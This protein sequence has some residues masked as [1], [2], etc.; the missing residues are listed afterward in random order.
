MTREEQGAGGLEISP[1]TQ[2]QFRISIADAVIF[3]CDDDADD[4][5]VFV[6]RITNQLKE[7]NIDATIFLYD[8]L[9]QQD[10]VLQAVDKQCKLSVQHWF[11]ITDSFCKDKTMMLHKDEQIVKSLM[12][13]NSFIPLWTKPKDEFDDLPYGIRAYRGLYA[14]DSRLKEK[15]EK[16]FKSGDHQANKQMIKENREK[17]KAQWLK[18]EK[19][20]REIEAKVRQEQHEERIRKMR[21]TIQANNPEAILPRSESE[22]TLQFHLLQQRQQQER[23]YQRKSPPGGSPQTPDGA[24]PEY[25]LN[26]LESQRRT[27]T[28]TGTVYNITINTPQQVYIGGPSQAEDQGAETVLKNIAANS[29]K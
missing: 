13:R 4:V 19:L 14:N 29:G 18:E 22:L 28:G 2:P 23:V 3:Y 27:G 6:E 17:E 24:M 5:D 12:N 26:S 11:Y 1:E 20:R 10:T 25:L 7:R 8:D 9:A 15:L 16:M 21:E